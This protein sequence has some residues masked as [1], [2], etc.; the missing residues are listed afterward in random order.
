MMSL[1]IWYHNIS[2]TI[3][4]W[5]YITYNISQYDVTTYHWQYIADNKMTMTIWCH[6]QYDITIYHL[7]YI[8]DNIILLTIYHNMMSQHITDNISRTIRWQWQYDVTYNMISQY[9]TY[10]T[11]SRFRYPRIALLLLSHPSAA[12]SVQHGKLLPSVSISILSTLLKPFH[13]T[14]YPSVWCFQCVHFP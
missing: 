6:L 1:T 13:A 4:H 9:I 14:L 10:N 11:M 12:L 5:Q 8:T 7:Q 2:L 3:Y